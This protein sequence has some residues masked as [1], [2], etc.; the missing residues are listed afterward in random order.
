MNANTKTPSE[1][2]RSTIPQPLLDR[3]ENEWHQMR[4]NAP[5]AP[6]TASDSPR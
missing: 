2:E 3:I 1:T 5:A 4:V 6:K